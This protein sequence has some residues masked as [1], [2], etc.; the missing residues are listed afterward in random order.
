LKAQFEE[1]KSKSTENREKM[2]AQEKLEWVY[3]H[4]LH[5]EKEH[6]RLPI[7]MVL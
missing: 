1:A 3:T 2:T 5:Y 7:F 4:S 6:N